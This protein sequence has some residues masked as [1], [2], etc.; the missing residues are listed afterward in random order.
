MTSS[1]FS[2]PHSS[3]LPY[4]RELARKGEVHFEN[5]RGMYL[6][7]SHRL[8]RKVLTDPHTFSCRNG[9]EDIFKDATPAPALLG[10]DPPDH[11]RLR[12]LA[13]SAFTP[14]TVAR[15]K[16]C[17]YEIAHRVLNEV[18]E[19]G[20]MDVVAD[21]SD[22]MP[23]MVIA[24]ILGLPL[25]DWK[26]FLR[27]SYCIAAAAAPTVTREREAD[28]RVPLLEMRRYLLAEIEDRRTSPTQ[29]LLSRFIHANVEGARLDTEEVLS[30]TMLLVSA[31]HGTTANGIA[32]GIRWLLA[33]PDQM[34]KLRRD[35]RLLPTAVEEILR[36]DPPMYMVPRV[37]TRSVELA[38]HTL[39]NGDRLLYVPATANRDEMVFPH[40]DRFDITRDPNPHL[41]FG[42]GIHF[43]LGAALARQEM[44]AALDVIL[45]RCLHLERADT[46]PLEHGG[47]VHLNGLKHLRVRFQPGPPCSVD[48]AAA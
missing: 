39:E 29:D 34:D 47:A 12:A 4:Y 27:W 19:A 32:Q 26:H 45:D 10:L 17:T 2:E 41:S 21:I 7:L 15:L 23:L 42:Y 33:H 40:P 22:K 3:C 18:I 30:L 37:V 43:C 31:G 36:Y 16:R 6:V 9:I 44:R 11:T 14:Q 38:G 25:D 48:V 20:A 24:G 5:S 46:A 8:V 13:A 1:N 35:R 28:H